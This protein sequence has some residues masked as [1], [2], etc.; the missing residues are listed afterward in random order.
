MNKITRDFV[1]LILA[2]VVLTAHVSCREADAQPVEPPPATD[3]SHPH[4]HEELPC[5]CLVVDEPCYFDCRD[6]L[7]DCLSVLPLCHPESGIC[8]ETE[9]ADRRDCHLALEDCKRRCR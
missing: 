2:G 6:T 3:H 7:G 5:E 4:D 1:A 8:R 9:A